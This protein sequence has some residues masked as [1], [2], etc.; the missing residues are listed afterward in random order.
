MNE[1]TIFLAAVEITDPAKRAAYLA[2]V[3]KGDAKLRRQVDALLTA[4]DKSGEFLDVPALQQMAGGDTG[5]HAAADAD[6]NLSF[7]QPSTTPGSLGRLGS[8]DIRELLGCGGC[9]IVFKAFDDRLNRPVA[10]KVLSPRARRHL[11]GPQTLCPR[12]P[13]RRRH[14]S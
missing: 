12:G 13:G 1:K 2:G 3:C 9:G 6:V 8:Y 4:H 14:S 7:L 10:I 5:E 11:A